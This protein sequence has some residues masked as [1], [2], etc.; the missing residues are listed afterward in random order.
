[1]SFDGRL[2]RWVSAGIISA[3]QAERIAAFELAALDR[4]RPAP[5]E[6]R[7]MLLYA[8]AG[9]AA[10]AIALGLVSIVAANWDDIRPPT[11]IGLDLALVATIGLGV[12]HWERRGIGWARETAIVILY[13]LVLASIALIGQVYQLGGEPHEA[14]LAWSVLTALLMTRAHSGFAGTVWILGLQATWATWAVWLAEQHDA[15]TLALGTI[16][17][18]PLLCL[19]LGRLPPLR[20]VRPALAAALESIGATELLLCAT[21][22][23][24]AFYE[25]TAS[26]PWADAYPAVAVSVALTVAIALGILAELPERLLLVTCTAL[27]HVPLFVSTGDLELAA[28]ASFVGLWLMVAWTAHHA[29]DARMLNVATAMIGLRIVAIYFEVFGTLLDTGL[30]LV[31]GGL[32]T[33]GLVWL[34]TRKRRQFERELGGGR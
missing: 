7:P 13:G 24:F 10:L 2:A 27:A 15:P 16:D 23:T 22:G 31:S 26:E 17:W 11:K 20:R 3:E 4:D 19:G 1:M 25:N 8:I 14:L 32:L 9:L 21:L 12:W 28:A 6:P 33:L 5:V 34:W 30:G 18:A 29:R